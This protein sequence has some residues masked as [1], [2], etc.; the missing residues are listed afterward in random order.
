MRQE[1]GES[2][3]SSISHTYT[4][5]TRDDKISA[6]RGG[7]VKLFHEYAGLG[8]DAGFY[9]AEAEGQVSRP[10]TSGLVRSVLKSFARRRES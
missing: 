9:K 7:Y 5:D 10:I 2:L 8:G 3:K 6:T 1:A 4:L